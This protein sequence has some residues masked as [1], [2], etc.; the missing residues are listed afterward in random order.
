MPVI[1]QPHDTFRLEAQECAEQRTNEGNET[2]E[3]RNAA[4]NAVGDDSCDGRATEPGGPMCDGVCRQVLRSTQDADENIL[5]GDLRA[6]VSAPRNTLH[7]DTWL[8][9]RYRVMDMI[10]PGIARP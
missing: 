8:T 7:R 6:L 3:R 10:S 9:W 4:G 1:V 5:G 2:T